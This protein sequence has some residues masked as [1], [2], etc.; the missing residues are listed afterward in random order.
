MWLFGDSFDHYTDLT[1]K[2]D[3]VGSAQ[4]ISAGNGRYST[5]CVRFTSA[6]GYLNKGVTP[7]SATATAFLSMAVKHTPS[8]S[9]NQPFANL[10]NSAL[11][12]GHVCFVL[13]TDGSISAW[14]QNFNEGPLQAVTI[15]GVL[16]GTTA[17]GLVATGVYSSLELSVVVHPS[18]GTVTIKVNGATALSLTSQDTQNSN[19]AVNTWSSWWIGQGVANG[20]LDIDDL[21]LYDSYNNGDGITTFLGDLTAECVLVSGAGAT[22]AWTKNTGASNAAAVDEAPPDGDTTYVSADTVGLTDTYAHGALTRIVAGVRCVQVVL[23]V[24][25]VGS[26][27]RAI[28][29]VIRRS[30]T[31]YP[32]A[33]L[34]LGTSYVTAVDARPKDPATSA[35]WTAANV[36]AAEIG[37]T[38]TV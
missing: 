13:N 1:T 23:T 28:A 19:A 17:A 34:Y 38:V 10:W 16:L 27:A 11:A 24:K 7:G 4:S 22:S 30:S 35:A 29:G 9:A 15:V 26:G 25:K 37:Q 12:R 32:G 8:I 2:Y 3:A 14:N 36:N 6:S 33:D 31:D 18:A 20:T 5:N 21:M